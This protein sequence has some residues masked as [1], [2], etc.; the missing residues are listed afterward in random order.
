[1][2]LTPDTPASGSAACEVAEFGTC[3]QLTARGVLDAAA[4]PALRAA[5]D[6]LELSPGGVLLLDLCGATSVD[7]A[8]VHFA[9]GLHGRA[10]TRGCSLVV[11]ARPDVRDLFALTGADELT[12]VA[13][14]TAD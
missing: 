2:V 3:V 8:V 14:A 9:L 5:A 11:V 10:A 7:T 12:I 4:V 1:V 6:G 13:D